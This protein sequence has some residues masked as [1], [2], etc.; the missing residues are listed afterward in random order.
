MFWPEGSQQKA[1]ANLRRTLASLNASL[2]GWIEADHA[3]IRLKRNAQSWVDVAAFLQMLPQLTE[4]NHPE[5]KVCDECLAVLEQA[6]ALYR[7]DFL[8]GE[9]IGDWHLE[10]HDRLQ[11]LYRDGLRAMGNQEAVLE[12]FEEAAGWFERL[13]AI[14]ELDEDAYRRI[15]TC[16]MRTGDR[17]VAAR[18]YQKL[19]DKL[20]AELGAEPSRE[21][22]AVFQQLQTV[23]RP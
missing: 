11:R 21:T 19:T 16:R 17:A 23:S 4:H 18:L 8:Q 6:V 22:K 15:M 12:H 9:K 5:N 20:E 1:L 14:D 2:P 13:I 3:T 10:I 7:G